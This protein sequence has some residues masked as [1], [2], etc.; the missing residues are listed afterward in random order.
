MYD[1]DWGFALR[2]GPQTVRQAITFINVNLQIPYNN[3]EAIQKRENVVF[4][5]IIFLFH[6]N[7]GLACNINV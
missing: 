7:V 3:R 6:N 4:K 5:Y 2:S 1:K